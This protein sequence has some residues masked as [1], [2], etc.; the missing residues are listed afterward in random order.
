MGDWGRNDTKVVNTI[1]ND[2][3]E[4]KST[5]D[6]KDYYDNYTYD[7]KTGLFTTYLSD[8]S[9]QSRVELAKELGCKGVFTFRMAYDKSTT[10]GQE[11]AKVIVNKS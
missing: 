1:K 5:I 6:G 4:I 3:V 8:R 10:S 2:I 11:I 7:E 9:I